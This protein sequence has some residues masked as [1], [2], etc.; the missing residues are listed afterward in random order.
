MKPNFKPFFD[1]L[2][3]ER[4]KTTEGGII[5][6]DSGIKGAKICKG[7]V[8]ATGVGI[9]TNNGVEIACKIKP[10]DMIAY[11]ESAVVQIRIDSTEYDILQE[12]QVIGVF[13]GEK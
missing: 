3:V 1:R 4:V 5:I 10:G 6:P 8:I 11:G 7:K 2:L 13:E 12:Y 9:T